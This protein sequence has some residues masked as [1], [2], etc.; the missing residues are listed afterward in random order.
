MTI[1]RSRPAIVG[2]MLLLS[3]VAAST[4]IALTE[5]SI[6][7]ERRAAAP[8]P[9]YTSTG[10][11]GC[12]HCHGGESIVAMS[13]T[14]HGDVDNPHAPY[15]GHGCESCHGAG[16]IHVSRA[17]GGVGFPPLLR[18]D[19]E[20]NG[21]AAINAP[22]TACHEKE[23]GEAEALEWS[24]SVHARE[25]VACVDCHTGI[26][27]QD[28][29]LVDRSSQAATCNGCHENIT[30][31]HAR[32]ENSGIVFDKLACYDCHDVHQLIGAEQE[33]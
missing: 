6:A 1:G 9:Q 32:F 16:S 31:M 18:F 25:K 14:T 10:T 7:Q 15:A 17:R 28:S 26:H 5:N 19:K 30:E 20:M 2:G 22:C 33:D 24:T 8:Q 12:L 23:M 21:A 27:I 4:L 3:L 13:E 29:S 11:E